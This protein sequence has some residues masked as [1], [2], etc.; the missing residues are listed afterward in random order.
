VRGGKKWY[1]AKWVGEVGE[2]AKVW[3]L[4]RIAEGR[5][6]V[7]RR[8][9]QNEIRLCTSSNRPLSSLLHPFNFFNN[10][11]KPD[12]LKY[13]AY[14]DYVNLVLAVPPGEQGSP[15]K[16]QY[17]GSSIQSAPEPRYLQGILLFSLNSVNSKCFQL[18]RYQNNLRDEGLPQ[19]MRGLL[20]PFV[21]IAESFLNPINSHS[22]LFLKVTASA[23]S[24]SPTITSPSTAARGPTG[25]K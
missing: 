21:V 19:E 14:M 5:F 7:G 4:I 22:F 18:R 3:I 13:E 1:G 25:L 17:R 9:H 15:C 20:S 12:G 24:I 23:G 8:S 6:I 10:Y 11:G 16:A 2:L